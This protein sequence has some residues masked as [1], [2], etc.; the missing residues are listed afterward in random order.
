MTLAKFRCAS[1]SGSG[2]HVVCL[3][4]K[5]SCSVHFLFNEFSDDKSDCSMLEYQ[6]SIRKIV[7]S[8]IEVG[9]REFDL[10]HQK[11]SV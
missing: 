8:E 9:E 4:S 7:C 6:H 2:D 1:W 5:H 10:W 11:M 3:F